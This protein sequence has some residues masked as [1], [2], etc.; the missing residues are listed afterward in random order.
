MQRLTGLDASFLYNETPT[1]HMHT[2]KLAILEPAPHGA[3]PTREIVRDEIARRLDHLPPFRRRLVEVP[4]RLHHPVW[5]EDPDFDIDDH[6]HRVAVPSPGG[7]AELDAVIGELASFPLDRRR[8]LWDLYVLDGLADGRIA[9]LVK[10]HH[11]AADG[12]AAP[13]A[14]GAARLAP[15]IA[16][17]DGA[18]TRPW[19]P[20]RPPTP[21]RLLVDALV[22]HLLRLRRLP[23]LIVETLRRSRRA[24]LERRSAPVRP[25]RPI[26]D[27]PRSPLGGSLTPRRSF[28][29][30][31]LPLADAKRVKDA[32]GVSLND[33]VLA[34]VAGALVG[35]L[36]E[37]GVRPARPLVAGVP[38]SSDRPDDVAR[39]GGNRV[40]NIFT[41]LATDLDDPLERLQAIHEVTSVAKQVH[42]LLGADLMEE[43]VEYTPPAPYSWMMRAYG[44]LGV[45][46]WHP[47][48][49]N[50][51]VSNVPG[52]RETL[53]AAG[54]P[55]AG[56]WSVGPILE[57][58]GCN[59]T[60]WSYLDRLHVGVLV[61]P[62]L[63]GEAS[64]LT[65]RLGPA[66]AELVA[67]V[68]GTLTVAE[69]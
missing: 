64:A 41:S 15:S 66:L 52:P 34:M 67:R 21:T 53:Y 27:T 10:I 37:A 45:A 35:W 51:V 28:S 39:L 54:A 25:P 68:E 3:R 5:V 69:G 33:V 40:S 65:A 22:D 59:V 50:L 30:I 23:F 24:G 16:G 61:C 2:L 56:I 13:R 57:G 58:V 55:L 48:P 19:S 62:D 8:P 29:R 42:N 46:N 12:D 60:V 36:D 9:V 44:R 38:V 7:P 43:W 20:D 11:A 17:A 32:C 14:G 26:L 49:I 47:P 1:L 31:D 4:L 6:V 63:A 18:R